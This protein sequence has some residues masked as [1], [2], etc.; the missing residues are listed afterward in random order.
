MDSQ[1]QADQPPEKTDVAFTLK[2]G[3]MPV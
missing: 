3:F 2:T 1:A